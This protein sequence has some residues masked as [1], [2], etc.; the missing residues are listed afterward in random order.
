MP[1]AGLVAMASTSSAAVGRPGSSEAR[2]EA[3]VEHA[4]AV[5]VD[6]REHVGQPAVVL[7][8]RGGRAARCELVALRVHVA[9]LDAREL[10]E[11]RRGGEREARIVGVHV[12]PHELAVRDHDERVAERR[13]LPLE[14]LARERAC[15]EEA[16]A[17]ARPRVVGRDR[18]VLVLPERSRI[19]HRLPAQG[20]ERTAHEL[21]QSGAA[22]VHDAGLAQH[23]QH[24]GRA[25]Q[26]DLGGGQAG[27]ERD[28]R[29]GGARGLGAVGE[30][31][32]DGQDRALD[33][34]PQRGVGLGA[35]AAQGVGDRR[36][37]ERTALA[38]PV[39]GAAHELREDDPRVAAGAEQRGTRADPR[40]RRRLRQ[41]VGLQRL[42]HGARRAREVRAR[43]AIRHREDVDVVDARGMPSE[44]TGCAGSGEAHERERIAGGGRSGHRS[45][46]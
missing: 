15:D 6:D 12:R 27:G 9:D 31:A 32:G 36:P 42:V 33:R 25:R 22:R 3:G 28:D 37:V 41:R 14:L 39:A 10:P 1:A 30:R 44:R 19:G 18:V 43:V 7:E 4:V 34:L 35:G 38:E 46:W 23:R 17:V 11:R 20:G 13:E 26:R 45:R 8:Q 29:I 16:G 5:A 40:D 24:V 21:D 2:A